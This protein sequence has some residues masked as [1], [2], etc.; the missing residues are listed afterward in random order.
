MIYK[1]KMQHPKRKTIKKFK[2]N[3]KNKIQIILIKM[4]IKSMKSTIG[5]QLLPICFIKKGKC[6]K[7]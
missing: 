3:K 1:N 2:E 4:N 6:L 5:Q 7:K